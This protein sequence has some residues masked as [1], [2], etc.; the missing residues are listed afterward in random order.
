MATSF[1][2]GQTV[3]ISG[4]FA[5]DGAA[6]DPDTVTFE[7]KLMPAG[8]PTSY[9]YNVDEE[10]IK[11]STGHYHLD[12]LPDIAGRWRY[13][14]SGVGASINVADGDWLEVKPKWSD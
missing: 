4:T 12:L 10:L 3:R 8:T 5:L 1:P 14:I 11:D 2:F 7:I 6:I 9:V 13:D